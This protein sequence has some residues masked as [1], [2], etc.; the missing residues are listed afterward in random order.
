MASYVYVAFEVWVTAVT[1]LST[2]GPVTV[3]GWPR[4][5]YVIVVVP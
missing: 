3:A 1:G 5:L 4:P 2:P